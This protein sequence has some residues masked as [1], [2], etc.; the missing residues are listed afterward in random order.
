MGD[1]AGLG[2]SGHGGRHAAHYQV[3]LEQLHELLVD[4]GGHGGFFLETRARHLEG[5]LVFSEG[6][7]EFLEGKGIKRQLALV[8][9]GEGGYVFVGDA[10]ER[11]G[12]DVIETVVLHEE[13]D[14]RAR[15][16]ALLDLVEE[17]ERVSRREGGAAECGELGDEGIGIE[18]PREDGFRFGGLNEVDLNGGAVVPLGEGADEVGLSH[19]SRAVHKQSAVVGI[20]LPTYKSLV[21]S[22]L[23]HDASFVADYSLS[24]VC[25]ENEKVSR[26][27]CDE[28]EKVTV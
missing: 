26:V 24:L 11:A 4:D 14:G 19:L 1:V 20:F 7:A 27:L 25:D 3:V 17:N 12:L 28:N 18:V 9:D 23:Q 6:P 22:S 2:E 16:R 21:G 10:E 8:A 5:C 15:P 13:L